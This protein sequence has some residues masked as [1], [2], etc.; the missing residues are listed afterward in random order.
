MRSNPPRRALPV[1][2]TLPQD[3]YRK[4]PKECV[5]VLYQHMDHTLIL[6]SASIGEPGH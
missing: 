2:A 3:Q 1:T 4:P 6:L 5:G